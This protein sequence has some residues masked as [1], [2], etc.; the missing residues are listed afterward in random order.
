[1]MNQYI[2]E[3]EQDPFDPDEFVERMVRRSMQESRLKDDEF[4]PEMIHDIFTQAIQDLKVL[5]ERQERKCARLEQSVQEEEKLY[6]AK[7]A[8]I[9]E[10]HTHCVNVFSSLDERMSRCGGR[11]LDVGEKLG[12]A[13][14]PRARAA[15]ARDLLAHLAHFLSPGPV[16]TELFND[17]SKLNEA[18][19]VIQKLHTIAQELPPDKF[20]VAKKKIEAKYDEIERNLIEEFV[21]AQNQGDMAKMKDIANIMTNFKGYSQCVDA[22]IETSQMNTLMGKDIF[23]S[24]LPLCKKNYNII[25]VVFSNPEQVMSKFV[26]NIFHLKLQKYIQTKLADK[27]D[28]EKYLRNLYDMYT[29]TQKAC[30]DLVSAGFI[31]DTGNP[32]PGSL[33]RSALVNGALAGAGDGYPALEGR[34]LRAL[35]SSLL[36]SY[37]SDKG[38]V[39]RQIQGAGFQELR[40]DLQ[41]VIGTR[42]NINIAQIENYGGETFLSDTLV[43]RILSEAKTSFTRCKTLCTPNELPGTATALLDVLIQHLLVEH[44]DYALDLGLQSIPIAESKSPPQIYFFDTVKECNKIVKMFEEHFQ[45][46]VLPCMNSTA[47]QTECVN[48]KTTIMEQLEAKLDAG[49][50]RAISAIVGWVK[51]HLQTE[52]KK[53]D[54][55][56]EGDVD[57]LASPACQSVVSYLNTVMEKIH[58]GLE[59]EN[60]QAVTLELAIRLHRVIYEHLQNFQFNFAGAMVAICDVKE[61]RSAAC[62][63]G[64]R[65]APPPAHAL[66]DALH[67]LCNLLLAKP[68]NLHQVCE[69]E[70]LA[71]LDHSILLNFIQLRSD[72]KSHKLSSFLK[73][74]S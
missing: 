63:R 43:S 5:Q 49:L 44:V 2:K 59:G 9:M 46:S 72:Y 3:L 1:M 34:R 36:H 13:R 45:E 62:G 17:P 29:S 53:S 11:A 24:V 51:L 68:E 31:S 65:A 7:L 15:A 12:A 35:L 16:H 71:E 42:A 48:K 14:A 38:H 73:G 47:K 41:A 25:S 37:Y 74:L 10:Q 56:P 8:E 64:A 27:N 32:S 22:F 33:R 21:K 69:G 52:Q 30:D 66:F 54:F 28:V 19:D 67:A 40:R 61:Y 6:G 39:K 60:L 50:E 4:D 55:K 23:A 18:A 58:S 26:L 70:T 20:E 57:T